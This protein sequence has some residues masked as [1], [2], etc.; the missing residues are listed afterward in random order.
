MKSYCKYESNCTSF[1][2][3]YCSIHAIQTPLLVF[4]CSSMAAVFAILV[5]RKHTRQLQ[6]SCFFLSHA[7]M[8]ER[9]GPSYMCVCVARAH[10]FLVAF[11]GP[12]NLFQYYENCQKRTLNTISN[13]RDVCYQFSFYVFGREEKS[14]STVPDVFVFRS[15]YSIQYNNT[16]HK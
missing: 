15:H 14:R 1:S 8:L 12:L 7:A 16:S 2:E 5:T 9:E 6:A 10:I 11:M 3:R 13:L 4:R